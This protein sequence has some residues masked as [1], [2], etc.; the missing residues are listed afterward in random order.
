MKHL[1]SMLIILIAIS[2]DSF[3][4]QPACDYKVEILADSEE[5]QKEDFKWRV[6]AT[7]IE[8][9]PTII[10]ATADIKNSN[11]TNVK[12]YK[13]WTL[14]PISKQ[15]T[16]DEYT[17]KMK[18]E[19]EYSIHARID[20][21]CEDKNISN[22]IDTR[23]IKIKGG[24]EKEEAKSVNNGSEIIKQIIKHDGVEEIKSKPSVIYESS[25]EKAKSLIMIFLLV[26]SILLNIVLIWKR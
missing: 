16:S 11:K 22:N 5:F 3:A 17:T 7:K 10:T 2:S 19:T 20:V 15:K 4:Q 18:E 24:K 6:R 8:G 21:G 26:L 12:S 1:L 9:A 25:N 14:E 13:P 23:K